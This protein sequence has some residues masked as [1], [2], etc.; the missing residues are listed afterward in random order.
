MGVWVDGP[1]EDRLPLVAGAK[2]K[3]E[4]RCTDCGYGVTVYR[5]LPRCPMCGTESWEQLE[6]IVSGRMS[7]A[8]QFR[9]IL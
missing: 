7:S 4:F 9:G 1:E 5:K 2:A 3:G 6:G 8:T